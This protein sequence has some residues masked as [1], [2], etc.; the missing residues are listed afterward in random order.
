LGNGRGKSDLF[1]S[2]ISLET[3]Y[4]LPHPVSGVRTQKEK[5]D[6]NVKCE[7]AIALFSFS[8][9]RP[10]PP[11]GRV[12]TLQQKGGGTKDSRE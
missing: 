11:P 12:I 7:N 10:L 1:F 5:R 6:L 2:L 4:S 9:C 8:V 3:H